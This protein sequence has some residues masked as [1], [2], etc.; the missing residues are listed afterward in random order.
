MGDWFASSVFHSSQAHFHLFLSLVDFR[1]MHIV[2]VHVAR[3]DANVATTLGQG[4]NAVQRYVG[5]TSTTSRLLFAQYE[6]DI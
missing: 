3:S 2:P 4:E 1:S 6:M 5:C